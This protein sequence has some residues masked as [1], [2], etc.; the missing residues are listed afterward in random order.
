MVTG[1]PLYGGA[2]LAVDATS[3][4]PLKA[5]GQP[6]S[7]SAGAALHN[8]RRRKETRYPELATS[9]RCRLVVTAMEVG[10]R[11]SEE[12]Y[13]FLTQLAAAKAAEA[14]TALRGSA[15]RCWVRRWS[16]MVS[17][18]AMRAFADTLLYDT[19]KEVELW[20]SGAPDLGTVLGEDA[21]GEAPSCS[22]LSWSN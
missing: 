21:H 11:W 1:L 17:V 22:R 3:V 6:H 13:D 19:A 7:R 8:A 16:A 10:G 2:Q 14:S 5:N 15:F 18:A 9:T 20:Y 12:A 4:S